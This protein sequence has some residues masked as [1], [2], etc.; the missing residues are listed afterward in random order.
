MNYFRSRAL[1][2]NTSLLP[3]VDY[4]GSIYPL[5]ASHDPVSISLL[6]FTLKGIRIQG[7]LVASRETIRNLLEFVA[8]KNIRPTIMTYPLTREGIEQ[9]MQELREGKVR[10]RA[11]L[12]RE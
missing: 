7:S 9:A 4:N 6:P 8:R 3:L 12:I 1:I 2:E 5:T 11:V 10:Y